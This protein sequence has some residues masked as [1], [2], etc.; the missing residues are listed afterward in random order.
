MAIAE[1]PN[2]RERCQ[3]TPMGWRSERVVWMFV[4][5]AVCA[6]SSAARAE[7]ANPAAGFRFAAVSD[8]SLG[9]WEGDKPVLV[10][11]HGLVA[12]PDVP[13]G[14]A[15]ACYFHPVYG[16]DGE[17]LTDDFP[18]DHTYHRGMYWAWPHVKIGE[19]EYDLWSARGELRQLFQRWLAQEANADTARLR[20][21]NGWFVGQR[22]LVREEMQIEVHP[23]TELG[24]ALDLELTWTPIDQPLTLWGAEG[25][26]YGGFNFRFGPRNKTVIT[27]P[28][29]STLSEGTTAAAGRLA[30]DLVVTRLPWA[31]FVGDFRSPDQFSGAAIF[32]H[33]QHRDYPPTWMARHY[34]L[35]SVGWPGVKPQTFEPGKPLTC[36]YRIWIHRGTPPAAAIEG[37]YEAYLKNAR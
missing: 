17:V 12:R 26:S 30:G 32:V 34:G 27:V 35:L 2:K 20:V 11:N 6:A 33:P 14:R 24:R 37:Q 9:L 22:L 15:R 16:L 5:F 28:E 7:I 21:E 3:E 19:Q 8:S 1:A 18:K 25:K 23:A 13:G 4:L 10:Y 31:D 36:R 29:G